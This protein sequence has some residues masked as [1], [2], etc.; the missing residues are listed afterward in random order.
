M[1]IFKEDVYLIIPLLG[2]VGIGIAD[3]VQDRKSKES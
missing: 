2:M 3:F 1:N